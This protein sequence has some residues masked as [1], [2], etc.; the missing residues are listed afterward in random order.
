MFD[1]YAILNHLLIDPRGNTLGVIRWPY[2]IFN[3]VEALCWLGI[4]LAILVRFGK[5]RKTKAELAYALSFFAFGLSDVIETSGTTLL[6][7]LFKGA[8]LLAILSYRRNIMPLY[9]TKRF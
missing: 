7:L 6:L 3:A 1:A 8:C 2:L 9:G 4:S 5:H